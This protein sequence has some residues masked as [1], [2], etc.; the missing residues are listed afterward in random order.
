MAR[1]LIGF[2]RMAGTRGGGHG[3]GATSGGWDGAW[4]G[5]AVG[6]AAADG[7]AGERAHFTRR[8]GGA[9]CGQGA[10]PLPSTLNRTPY[11]HN[12][13]ASFLL[14]RYASSSSLTRYASSPYS[15]S[16]AE[17][18]T[19]KRHFFLVIGAISLRDTSAS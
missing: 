5:G 8:E 16:V 1:G 6:W 10:H 18:F 9:R 12:P 2:A 7:R 19:M 4:W 15:R 13:V 11:T 17:I 3:G 14:T